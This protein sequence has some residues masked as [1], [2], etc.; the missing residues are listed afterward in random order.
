M[1]PT[2]PRPFPVLSGREAYV[3]P[4]SVQDVKSCTTVESAFPAHERCS[5]EK[6]TIPFSILLILHQVL[7]KNSSVID[8]AIYPI[9]ASDYS[10]KK[11]KMTDLSDT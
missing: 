10:S 3:R 11:N 5:E 9:Y 4:L 8:S 6:V 2:S 1:D 7:T